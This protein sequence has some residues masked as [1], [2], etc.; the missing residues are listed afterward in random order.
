MM[1]TAWAY[2]MSGMLPAVLWAGLIH[3]PGGGLENVALFFGWFIG[4]LSLLSA[5][6]K[7]ELE[8]ARTHLVW[9]QLRAVAVCAIPAWAG[10]FALA[11]VLL[12]GCAMVIHA[13]EMTAKAKRAEA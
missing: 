1:K 2:F 10:Q 12:I 9:R 11:A 6:P 4:I 3:E 7:V 5:L 13:I 8:E